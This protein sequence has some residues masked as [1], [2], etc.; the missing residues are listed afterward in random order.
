MLTKTGMITGD[1]WLVTGGGEKTGYTYI[2]NGSTWVANAA[3]SGTKFI[4]DA[5]AG[6]ITL[7]AE[8]TLTLTTGGV[9]KFLE[10]LV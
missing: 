2:Y 3:I 4:L 8:N 10:L 7:T 9:L 5:N 6:T 1:S